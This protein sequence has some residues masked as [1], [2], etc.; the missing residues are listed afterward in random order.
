MHSEPQRVLMI[1]ENS[2]NRFFEM[3][4]TCR[5]KMSISIGD[6]TTMRGNPELP[7][8]VLGDCS[9]QG[10]WKSVRN[11]EVAKLVVLVAAQSLVPRTDPNSPGS[12]LIDRID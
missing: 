10:I 8:V 6:E 4:N 9:Y 11:R 1:L 12:I 3:R 2:F 5:R 7:L